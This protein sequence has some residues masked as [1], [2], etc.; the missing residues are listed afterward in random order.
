MKSKQKESQITLLLEPVEEEDA[1]KKGTISTFLQSRIHESFTRAAD[2]L[3]AMGLLTTEERIAISGCIG[4]ALEAFSNIMAEKVPDASDIEV[5][6]EIAQEILHNAILHRRQGIVKVAQEEL[7]VP[8]SPEYLDLS[9]RD[10]DHRTLRT[11]IELALVDEANTA[12]HYDNMLDVLEQVDLSVDMDHPNRKAVEEILNDERDHERILLRMLGQD[13][14][15]AA[16]RLEEVSQLSTAARH[17]F[18]KCMRC[19][20]S[21][22]HEMM[23]A[24]GRAHAWFCEPHLKEFISE[25]HDRRNGSDIPEIKELPEGKAYK[26]TYENPGPNIKGRF[27]KKAALFNSE[28][29]RVR[30]KHV[31]STCMECSSPPTHEVLWANG[32]GHAWF[33][34]THMRQFF[35]SHPGDVNAVKK[36]D[37]GEA[38]KRF[39]DN[40]NKNI[41]DEISGQL[42]AAA[43]PQTEKELLE[44][45][46]KLEH[47]QWAHWTDYM[48]NNLTPDNITK[49]VQ[50][51]DTPYQD[52]SDKEKKS[53]REWAEKALDIVEKKL[54]SEISDILLSLEAQREIGDSRFWQKMWS[55]FL[56]THDT[57]ALPATEAAFYEELIAIKRA[58][59]ER[60]RFDPN[61]TENE[62]RWRLMDPK[63]F[64]QGSIRR[65]N[66]WKEIKASG[67]QFVMGKDT[68]D[69]EWKPQAIRF[70]KS[71]DKGQSLWTE[72][73]AAGWWNQNK[74]QFEKE[75]AQTSWDTWM[76]KHPSEVFAGYTGQRPREAAQAV[77]KQAFSGVCD[78]CS[79]HSDLLAKHRIKPGWEGGEY[80]PENIQNLC[81]DC[82]TIVHQE[83]GEFEMGGRWRHDILKKELGEEGYVEWQS[84]RGKERQL[85]LREMLGEDA[86]AA[87]QRF[88]ALKR[89]HPKLVGDVSPE[90]FLEQLYVTPPTEYAALFPLEAAV[91]DTPKTLAIDLDGTIL[92]YDGFKGIDVFGEPIDGARET[93]Q[94]FKDDGWFIV[95]DTCRGDVPL[96]VE[97]LA[98]YDIPFDTVNV[99]PFQPDT[100]NPGKPMADFRIDD[101]AIYFNGDWDE[102]YVEVERRGREKEL[103]AVKIAW[104]PPVDVEVALW[105]LS[106]S[107]M[108]EEWSSVLPQVDG[109]IVDEVVTSWTTDQNIYRMVRCG[110]EY[111]VFR[112]FDVIYRSGGSLSPFEQVKVCSDITEL[113]TSL[114]TPSTIVRDA[115]SDLLARLRNRSFNAPSE[116]LGVVG[117]DVSDGGRII[118]V[119]VDSEKFKQRNPA[120]AVF[121]TNGTV[122]DLLRHIAHNG[123]FAY[124]PQKGIL[125]DFVDP[126]GHRTQPQ[127]YRDPVCWGVPEELKERARKR[128]E[129]QKRPAEAPGETSDRVRR[130]R[131]VAL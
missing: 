10:Q 47:D 39:R 12:Q 81:P 26:S 105:D 75:W 128:R 68:R 122:S 65:W 30:G 3:Y 15:Q 35:K 46:S 25:E 130:L 27:F 90:E 8:I 104:I 69:D 73:K 114:T 16:I 66:V 18:D 45:L 1:E 57:Q 123:A 89:W 129:R 94:R 124:D 110:S 21:P 102:V 48:L 54:P 113:G 84:E 29:L 125:F 107:L 11:L 5:P 85:G 52:L 34:D 96:V 108:D 76:Q 78:R 72:E 43:L 36:I 93:L 38:G 2:Q 92:T 109:T 131:E 115:I 59:Q 62:G 80:V 31:R 64:E 86:Y 56:A 4:D 83:T 74:G 111:K 87:Y 9:D 106:D 58:A 32:K 120:L 126:F 97:H 7:G 95:I 91:R 61:S 121:A 71:D 82:H 70:K 41:V 22:T 77:I 98:M 24:D 40:A 117:G 99:N 127:D 51:I 49:W 67:V 55:R 13:E 103:F 79:E 42:K 101:S 44:E 33:C 6:V 19:S 37:D 119:E 112:N 14:S 23:W 60:F 20:K 50:Q 28:E 53:D 17:S 118:R 116:W 88:I 100:A 63:I